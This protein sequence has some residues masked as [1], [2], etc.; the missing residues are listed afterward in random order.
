MSLAPGYLALIS[1]RLLFRVHSP[2]PLN[3][4]RNI[5]KL[6][7]HDS[8]NALCQYS[9]TWDTTVHLLLGSHGC[10]FTKDKETPLQEIG[11]LREGEVPREAHVARGTNT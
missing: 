11:D 7:V 9:S 8:Q 10:P 4:E 5:Y 2:D 3:H 6:C 1:Q